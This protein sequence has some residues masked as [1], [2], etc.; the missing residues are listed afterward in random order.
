V[1]F[2]VPVKQSSLLLALLILAACSDPAPITI[3][4]P[5]KHDPSTEEPTQPDQ[6]PIEAQPM[7]EPLPPKTPSPPAPESPEPPQPSLGTVPPSD[8]FGVRLAENQT[9]FRVFSPTAESVTLLLFQ[10]AD[11]GTVHEEHPLEQDEQDVWE[12]TLPRNLEGLFY[13][14]RLTGPGLNPDHQAVDLYAT[15]TVNSTRR[16]R[17]TDLSKTNPPK[18]NELKQG[19][20]LD[21]PL[22][23]IIYE[24]HI[25]DLTVA[26]NSGVKQKKGYLG[27][28]ESG[29]TLPG[30]LQIKTALDHIEEMGVTHVH[31]LPIHDFENDES[32]D[33]YNWGY[34]TQNF[35]SPEGMYASNS[36]DDSRIR[37]F[38]QLVAALHQ[39]G[40]GVVLDVVYN[41]TGHSAHF[42]AFA[43]GYYYRKNPDGSYS[44]GSKCGND[45]RTEAPL[46]RRHIIDS[47]K[48]WVEE[49]GIDG[50]RFDL[51]ALM[52]LDTINQ[53]AR[54]LRKIK[55][56]ILL[57]G[58]PWAAGP[59][60][61][62]GTPTD[63]YHLSETTLAAFNDEFR[64]ALKGSPDG[65]DP[66][67]IQGD[68]EKMEDILD[69]I[70]GTNSWIL[71]PFQSINY[72]TCHDN[73]VLIDKLDKS[74]GSASS[75]DKRQMMQ[76]GYFLVLTSQGI[77]FLHAGEEF[78]RSKNG[79]HN[80]YNAGD[81]INQI[82][83]ELKARH[84]DLYENIR[85]LIQLRKDHPL[86]R[87]RAAREVRKRLKVHHS[88]GHG[89]LYTIDGTGLTGE[90][91][92]KACILINAHPS[93]SIEFQL[94]EG[95]WQVGYQFSQ[96]NAQPNLREN[97]CKLPETSAAVL[98]LPGNQ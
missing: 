80:S 3:E 26:S 45:F 44:N 89:I 53:A 50:F 36:N 40:I 96:R 69:G 54:E 14:Y 31:I 88:D 6:K 20:Q 95:T 64:N 41:H 27:W 74:A 75:P 18:W 48:F 58:E 10:S 70:T 90:S 56:D 32:S 83:W 98:Y 22:D 57:Y 11:G 43:P 61:M 30:N 47:L 76:L 35:F 49:Y 92:S 60:A 8:F 15:N 71:D 73:L 7:P 34:M 91:W 65:D 23:A 78:V 1:S 33:D 21:S 81:D 66:G 67:F 52:D 38:K 24:A 97:T 77:P 51:M 59:T 37:E 87:L 12:L 72:M 28:T 55:P 5:Q 94:P 85:T 17:I 13:A 84:Q 63:K 4:R 9:A 19:P 46:A 25:R 82:D 86:F 39:R 16:A 29:T 68:S 79:N 2:P 93:E 42:N 62:Q